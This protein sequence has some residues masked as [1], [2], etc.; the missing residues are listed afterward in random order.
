VNDE[1]R[2]LGNGVELRVGDHDRDLDDP[3]AVRVE[4]GHLHVEPREIV[5]VLRHLPGCAR[6]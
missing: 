1:N 4:P 5:L 6:N 2:R 3:V